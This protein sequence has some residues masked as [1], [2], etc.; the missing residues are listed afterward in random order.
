MKQLYENGTI[1]TMEQDQML[2]EAICIE[3]NKI[4]ATGTKKDLETAY[5]DAKIVDLNGKTMLPAFLDAHSHFTG[6]AN[7]LRLCDLSNVTS[8]DELVDVM[9]TFAKE[10][11]VSSTDWIIGTNYDHNYMKEKEHP[12]RLVLDRISDTNPIY[13]S[14]ASSHMGVV[15]TKAFEVMKVD[16]NVQDPK[17]GKYGRFEDGSLNGYMEESVFVDFISRV[18]MP[19]IEDMMKLYKQAQTIYASYGITTVQEGFTNHGLLQLLQAAASKD[20]FY[21]DVIAYVDVK[22]KEDLCDLYPAYEQYQHHLKIG[23]YKTFLDGSPQGKTAWMQEPYKDSGDYCGYPAMTKE[24]LEQ[25]ILKSVQK[26]RQL[27]IHC[28]GDAAAKEYVDEFYK[29]AKLNPGKELKRPVMIH[30][31]LVRKEEL[32]RMNEIQMIP[33]FFVAHTWYWGDIHIR[34][35]G[36]ERASMISPVQTAKQFHLPYTFHNDTPVIPADMMKTVWCAVNRQTKNGVTIGEEEAVSVEDALKAIT[37]HAAYQYFEEDV[38]G[39]L[40]AGKHADFIILD[41]NPLSIDKLDLA[42]IVVLETWKDGVCIY[43]RNA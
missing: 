11:Q 38:K 12:T 10:H 28:N 42:D 15:N 43:Q 21:L 7:S 25:V 1:I 27:L 2:V 40:K 16:P 5:P 31:Q 3:D 37:I 36:M 35:F 23:G 26:E 30:A 13:I 34:N 41:K 32:E 29:V 17:D 6:F 20:T 33:S 4:I 39:S 24:E 14:H 22:E 9:K 19:T 18:P 8:F